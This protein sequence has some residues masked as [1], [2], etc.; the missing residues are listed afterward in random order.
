MI[1][2]SCSVIWTH[3]DDWVWWL[4][5]LTPDDPFTCKCRSPLWMRETRQS[6]SLIPIS[7]DRLFMLSHQKEWSMSVNEVLWSLV[8]KQVSLHMHYKGSLI[9]KMI[10]HSWYACPSKKKL[11]FGIC[12]RSQLKLGWTW[13]LEDGFSPVQKTLFKH[14]WQGLQTEWC[15]RIARMRRNA[16]HAFDFRLWF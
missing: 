4:A 15:T 5:L 11:D 7:E 16:L 8:I 13:S 14:E 12:S 3:V 2:R 9:K 1:R 6:Q 10:I